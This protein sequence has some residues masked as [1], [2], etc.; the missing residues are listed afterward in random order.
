MGIWTNF[1][2]GCCCST[3]LST[4][5][6]WLGNKLSLWPFSISGVEEFLF[7][8]SYSES[9]CLVFVHVDRDMFA[10]MFGFLLIAIW[11]FSI[12]IGLIMYRILAIVLLCMSPFM[13]PFLYY[14]LPQNGLAR[15]YLPLLLVTTIFFVCLILMPHWIEKGEFFLND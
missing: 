15:E 3:N 5:P 1:C 13:W 4:L 9:Y 6:V 7:V 2:D 12:M 8:S 10:F 14:C 11:M